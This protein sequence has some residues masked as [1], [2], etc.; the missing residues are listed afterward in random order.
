MSG[1]DLPFGEVALPAPQAAPAA[2]LSDTLLAC[3][4][5]GMLA[6][7]DVA[8]KVGGFHRFYRM[9][10]KWPTLRA[11][12]A[13]R[14]DEVVARTCAAMDRARVYYFKRAWCLQRAAATVCLLRLRGVRAELVIGVRKIPF[15]AHAWTEVEQVVVNDQRWVRTTYA[16][17]SRC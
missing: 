10:E 9:V 2:T 15:A 3:A 13:E 7:V 14:R 12:S 8:L 6:F 4:A 5:W 16:E 1:F 11:P 17:V